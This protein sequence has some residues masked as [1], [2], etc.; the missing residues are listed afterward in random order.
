M[1]ISGKNRDIFN[2]LLNVGDNAA[3]IALLFQSQGLIL[4]PSL[5]SAS[6]LLDETTQQAL[7]NADPPFTSVIEPNVSVN[8]DQAC[9]DEGFGDSQGSGTPSFSLLYLLFKQRA[10]LWC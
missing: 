2:H 8:G 5:H 3:F 10:H 4:G 9:L 6:L 7:A 1:P